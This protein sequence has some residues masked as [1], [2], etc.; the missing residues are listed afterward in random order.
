VSRSAL[1]RVTALGRPP[2]GWVAVSALLGTLAIG[3]GL[4]LMAASG[5]L[6][7]AAA[8]QPPILSLGAVIVAVRFF[9]VSR[10]VFRYLERLASHD[11]TL[12]ALVGLRVALYRRLEPLVPGDLGPVRVG[13]LLQRFVGDVDVLQN[14]LLRIRLPLVTA[15]AASAL[16]VGAAA[17]FHPASAIVLLAGLAAAGAALPAITSSLGRR[18][19]AQEAPAQ[20]A[21]A[22]ELVDA[23]RCAPELVA[24]GRADDALAR[25][26]EASARLTRIRRRTAL[27]AALGEG[28]TTA[29]TLLTAVGVLAVA[30]PA[31]GDGSLPGTQLALLA[32]LAL[33]AFEAVR[34][35]PGALEQL[36]V[37]RGAAERIAAVVEREPSVGDPDDPAPFAEPATLRLDEV[38]FRYADGLPW[39][40]DGASLEVRRGEV[41]ALTGPSGSG[42]S[43]VA[44]LLMRFR[45]PSSGHIRLDDVDA[46]RLRPED[47]RRAV[48]LA[49]QDA[50]LFP[51][52]IRENLRIGAPFADDA[53]LLAALD[54]ARALAWVESLPDGLATRVAEDGGNVS[55]GQRQRLAL[56]RALLAE[57]PFLILDEPTAHLDPDT[58]GP[59]L[60]D[61]LGAAREAGLGVLLITHDRIAPGLV[62]DVL[63]LRDGRIEAR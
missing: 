5:Y 42:K 8:L 54:R 25:V 13:D 16:A 38:R 55:G 48:A 57:R 11:A 31:V 41:V 52:S 14:D 2:V 10:G 58:A 59:L 6:I 39:V 56:A 28:G 26:D 35:V 50:H 40:L 7:S 33:A 37:C 22:A 34:P 61:L 15:V 47:V 46:R 17:V 19:A 4:G 27:A 43:T 53:A 51:M 12:R 1:S 60:R 44:A 62:D 18:A 24:F 3:A 45:D 20:A 63:E 36:A 21:V 30:I 29:L 23:L 32:L 49:G 9:G